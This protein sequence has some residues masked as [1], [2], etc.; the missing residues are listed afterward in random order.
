MEMKVLPFGL[1]SAPATFQRLMEQVLRGLHWKTALLYL[2][3][4]IVIAPDFS[5]HLQRLEEVLQRL[6][7]AGLKL[8]PQKCELLQRK[9][10]YLGHIVSADGIATDPEKIEAI[11]DWPP[12]QNLKQ[13]QAFLGT[14]GYY[15]QYLPEFATIAKPLHELNSKGVEWRWDQQTQEAFDE[16][17]QRLI[18]APILGYPDPGLRYILDTDASDVGVGA[19]LSQVQQSRERVIAYF[20]KTLTPAER[21]YCVTRRELLAVVKAVKHFRPYLYGQKFLLRTDHA[22]LMWLC[23]R[24]EPSNQ[25]A[26]WLELL[27]EFTYDTEHR[28]GERHGNADGLSRRA[29]LDCKQC[30]RIEQ[31]D[32]GPSHQQLAAEVEPGPLHPSGG[33]QG[34]GPATRRALQGA[35]THYGAEDPEDMVEQTGPPESSEVARVEQSA[36]PVELQKLQSEGEGPVPTMYQSVLAEEPLTAEEL[37]VGSKELRQL[38]QRRHSMR[39]SE[40]GLLEIRVSPQSKARWCV[41]CPPALRTTTIW[42]AHSMAHS[43]MSRTLSRIQLAWYWPGM[44]AEVRRVVQSCEVCQAAKSGGTQSA[45]GRK[46][47]YAGRPWQRVAV[48]LVGPMPETIRGNKWILVLTDHF[49][50]WQDAIALPDATAPVVATA[51]DERVFCYLGLPEQIHTDQGAQFES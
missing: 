33:L 40:K 10:R 22:S 46:R 11:E 24:H 2:D 48:D 1:T 9:V 49:T 13:L 34:A 41:I 14:A 31:R 19:V 51:L 38:H 43:G 17:R 26:R 42:Q 20:S 7:G 23:R 29:C 36:T 18:T 21:N 45:S 37:T 8:K 6:Q 5:S 16:L 35:G 12:P 3:E 30:E 27:Y 15:R 44:T 50:R 32:G 28:K 39:I 47:L 25:I 4:V